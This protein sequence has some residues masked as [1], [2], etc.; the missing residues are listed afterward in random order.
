MSI[1]PLCQ[2]IMLISKCYVW[3]NRVFDNIFDTT[4]Q[5]L[6]IRQWLKSALYSINGKGALF[7]VGFGSLRKLEPCKIYILILEYVKFFNSLWKINE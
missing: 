2:K 5:D 7:T 3:L 6:S 1:V 4:F